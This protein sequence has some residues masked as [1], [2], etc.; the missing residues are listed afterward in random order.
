MGLQDNRI[1]D[2]FENTTLEEGI[3][4]IPIKW[5]RC[6]ICG[7]DFALIVD[8]DEDPFSTVPTYCPFCSS[9]RFKVMKIHPDND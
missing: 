8:T 6:K 3:E 5:I 2:I 9:F 1:D 7:A 4:V